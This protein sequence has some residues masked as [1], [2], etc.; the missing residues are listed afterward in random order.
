MN[1]NNKE[2]SYSVFNEVNWQYNVDKAFFLIALGILYSFIRLAQHNFEASDIELLARLL[3]GP[4]TVLFVVVL[5]ESFIAV[6]VKIAFEPGIL[7]ETKFKVI[8]IVFWNTL[9]ESYRKVLEYKQVYFIKT[10]HIKPA[11]IYFGSISLGN[12]LNNFQGSIHIEGYLK[13]PEHF[14]LK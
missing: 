4:F 13:E 6:L 7:Y 9:K 10:I 5:I 12:G 3:T 2:F 14:K 1:E 8:P 11:A